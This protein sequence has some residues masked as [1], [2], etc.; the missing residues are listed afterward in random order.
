MSFIKNTYVVSPLFDSWKKVEIRFNFWFSSHTSSSYKATEGKPQFILEGYSETGE[1]L[2]S[3]EISIAKS[4]IPNNNTSKWITY[5]LR[6]TSMRF[7]VL[8]W[9][10]Y[11]PNGN[12]GY[13]AVLCYAK[14]KGWDYN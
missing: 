4:D 14:L 12:S 10:N 11:I 5:Y 9:N 6:D 7:F 1:K 8:R 3:E 13:S 2:T